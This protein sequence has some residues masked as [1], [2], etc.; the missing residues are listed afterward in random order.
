MEDAL[1]KKIIDNPE[2]LT[3]EQREILE[4]AHKSVGQKIKEGMVKFAVKTIDQC[5]VM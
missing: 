3:C 4:Y 5:T 2:K 1:R